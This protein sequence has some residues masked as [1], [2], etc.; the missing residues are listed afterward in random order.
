VIRAFDD[1]FV[2]VQSIANPAMF[3][4]RVL[5]IS[6][7]AT[8]SDANPNPIAASALPGRPK[9][10]VIQMTE[11]ARLTKSTCRT[12]R[13]RISVPMDLATKTTGPEVSAFKAASICLNTCISCKSTYGVV[14]SACHGRYETLLTSSLPPLSRS[15][16]TGIEIAGPC[17]VYPLPGRT[18][19]MTGIYPLTSDH[20]MIRTSPTLCA[21]ESMRPSLVHSATDSESAVA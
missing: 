2:C 8:R 5:G 7:P 11:T 14:L 3:W 15:A 4:Q 10:G 21:Y 6:E 9:S 16:K 1:K 17:A 19:M 18:M 12:T 13:V 20:Q